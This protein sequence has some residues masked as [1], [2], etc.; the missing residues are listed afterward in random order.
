MNWK[1]IAS[2]TQT[3]NQQTG[4]FTVYLYTKLGNSYAI[5]CYSDGTIVPNWDTKEDFT[6]LL[7]TRFK[8]WLS[9]QEKYQTRPVNTTK[10]ANILIK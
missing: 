6:G 1:S 2:F 10:F 7:Q 5:H 4:R 8:V 3:G 9:E